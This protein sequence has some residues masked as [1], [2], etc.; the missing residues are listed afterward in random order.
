MRID[1]SASYRSSGAQ[2]GAEMPKII[3]VDRSGKEHLIDA[4]VGMSV[5][6]NIRDAGLDE[7]L[8]I[9]G[10]SMSCAT[11]HVHVDKAWIGELGDINDD[12]EA[13][14]ETSQHRGVYSRLSCQIKITE[15]LD[16]LRVVIAPEDS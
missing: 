15:T 9:C 8:A 10:G 2:N 3:V 4:R 6:E 7:L 12:E 16:G 1:R 14:L 13:L 5:M 11:C